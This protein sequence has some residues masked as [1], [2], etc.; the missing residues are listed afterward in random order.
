VLNQSYPHWHALIGMTDSGFSHKSA[1]AVSGC[2]V[3]MNGAALYHVARR[4][5]TVSQTSAEAE[6]KATALMSEALSAVVPLWS[7]IAGAGHPAVRVFID[8]KAAK[9]QCESG[10]DTVASAPY[11]EVRRTASP[12]ST[13]VSCG[14][15]LFREERT[16]L[17]WER[18][19]FALRRS[20]RRRTGF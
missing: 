3:L 15:I 16:V 2:S 11:L 10:T 6:V 4:Q 13:L 5:T 12:R 8:N 7:E 18:S 17:T 20:S 9:K 19:R 1:K 14:L